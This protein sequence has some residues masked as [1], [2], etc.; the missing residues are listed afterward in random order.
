MSYKL[1]KIFCENAVLPANVPVRIWGE[2]DYPVTVSID[3]HSG[4][5]FAKDGK[6]SLTIDPHKEGGPYVMFIESEGVVTKIPN[7]YFGDADPKD[8]E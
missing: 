4:V 3:Y 1:D 5:C 7:I 2:A 6:F 8:F